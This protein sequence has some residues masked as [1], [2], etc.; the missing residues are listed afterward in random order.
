MLSIRS[1]C[2][3]KT[4]SPSSVVAPVSAQW[5]FS[6]QTLVIVLVCVSAIWRPSGAGIPDVE[7]RPIWRQTI[8]VRPSRSTCS[9]SVPAGY[10]VVVLDT[11]HPLPSTDQYSGESSRRAAI[12]TSLD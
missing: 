2:S 1:N 5:L 9:S 11:N 3:D 7:S 8:L 10:R 6:I 12:G 4:P